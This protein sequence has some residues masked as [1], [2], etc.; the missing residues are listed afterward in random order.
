MKDLQDKKTGFLQNLTVYYRQTALHSN[1][2]PTTYQT[3]ANLL[4][5]LH[6]HILISDLNKYSHVIYLNG[7]LN[8]LMRKWMVT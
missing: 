7:Y 2:R 5:L 6:L 8:G 4:T 1:L 3:W